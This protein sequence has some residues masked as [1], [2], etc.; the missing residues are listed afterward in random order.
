MHVREVSKGKMVFDVAVFPLLL[1]MSTRY[2]VEE[3]LTN[4]TQKNVPIPDVKVSF[5]P[6]ILVINHALPP[7]LSAKAVLHFLK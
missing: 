4:I 3:N 7:P 1:A 6:C 5:S 2:S